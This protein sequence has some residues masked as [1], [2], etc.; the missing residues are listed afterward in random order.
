LLYPEED[1][2]T[3]ISY[4]SLEKEERDGEDRVCEGEHKQKHSEKII[5]KLQLSA[6]EFFMSLECK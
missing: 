1:S 2:L 5:L 4:F 6:N 3:S